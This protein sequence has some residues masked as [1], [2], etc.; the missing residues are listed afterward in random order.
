MVQSAEST[1]GE[2]FAPRS[3]TH[4]C[5][6]T[7]WRILGESEVRP[8]FMIIANVLGHQPLQVLLIQDDHV[9]QQVSAATPHPALRDTVLPRTAKGSADRLAS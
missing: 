8:I 3:R 7:C 9:V 1:E 5:W 6:P 2:N 4:R